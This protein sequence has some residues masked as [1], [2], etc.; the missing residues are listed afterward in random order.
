[1]KIRSIRKFTLPSGPILSLILIGLLLLSAILYYRAVNI[2]RFLEPALALSEPRIEFNQ[3]INSLL[4][5]EFG[6]DEVK[7]IKFKSRSILIEQSML[8]DSELGI[9]RS[10]SLIMKKLSHFFLS[11][12]NDKTIRD[13]ISLILVGIRLPLSPDTELSKERRFRMEERA[14]LILNSLYAA[15]PKLE[16]D[17]GTYFAATVMPVKPTAKETEWI[18]FRI[19][20][21]EWLHI[22][23]LQ[24]LEKYAH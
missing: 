9:K 12:L 17:Y 6:K 21:T 19:V 20:P 15:E 1:M 3:N 22:E 2:Q 16:R 7:D 8:F 10:E 11:A 4:S 18:E 13:H 14:R 24:R 23:V 5:K